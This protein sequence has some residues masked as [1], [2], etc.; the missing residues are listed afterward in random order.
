MIYVFLANGFEETEAIVPVDCC[1]R[2]EM[3]VTLVGVGCRIIKSSHGVTVHTDILDSEIVL[4]KNIKMIIL[5]GG[6]P[7][8][9]NLEKSKYV[10]EAID[11][12]MDKDI[13]IAAICAA[14]SILGHK[15]LLVGREATC[16]EGF[17]Q[18]LI[19]AKLSSKSVCKDGNII[20]AKGM[21]VAFQFAFEIVET[22]TSKE[23]VD[24]LKLCLEYE[25]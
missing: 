21:G 14:P 19:G 11:F 22:L 17:E 24:R 2:C 20:T 12:C 13:P 25:C 1:R 9:I 8:T 15:N 5:P 18:E 16:F 7:G 6:M 23:E 3:D 10:Q 4:D